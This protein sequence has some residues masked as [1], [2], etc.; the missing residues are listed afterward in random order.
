MNNKKVYC[1]KCFYYSKEIR[2][3]NFPFPLQKARCLH[4]NNEQINDSPSGP[5]R[6]FIHSPDQVNWDNK[7]SAF[8]PAWPS[9]CISLGVL[10]VLLSALIYGFIRILR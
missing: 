6:V 3:R 8:K 1:K 4:P 7:C 10:A 9:I 2:S 5:Y